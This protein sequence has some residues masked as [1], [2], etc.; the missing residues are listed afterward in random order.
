[1]IKIIVL[2]CSPKQQLKSSPTFQIATK[3]R[4]YKVSVS[5]TVT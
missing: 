5:E 2:N 1:M 4:S 3:K